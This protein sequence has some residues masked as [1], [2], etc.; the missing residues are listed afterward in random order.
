MLVNVC[1][2]EGE[3]D[4]MFDVVVD[5]VYLGAEGHCTWNSREWFV[6]EVK[7]RCGSGDFVFEAC[8]LVVDA[9]QEVLDSRV[10][11]G[12]LDFVKEVLVLGVVNIRDIAW[13][14]KGE[15]Y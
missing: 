1:N 2:V 10:G 13:L 3:V 5:G 15:P 4:A 6:E 9:W 11:V 12:V 14:V 7:F 8:E